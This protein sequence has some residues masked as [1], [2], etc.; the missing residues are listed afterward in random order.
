MVTG[1]LQVTVLSL[2]MVTGLLFLTT[3]P[4][5]NLALGAE[6]KSVVDD[7]VST[8]VTKMGNV[9]YGLTDEF[10]SSEKATFDKVIRNTDAYTME[11]PFAS[12]ASV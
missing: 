4:L 10:D 9:F 3:H 1:Y 2:V 11:N 8:T 6:I 5:I 7:L 12:L